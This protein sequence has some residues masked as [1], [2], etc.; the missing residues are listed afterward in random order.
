MRRKTARRINFKITYDD[1]TIPELKELLN[2]RNIDW[3]KL[4][5]SGKSSH[6][7][8][9]FITALESS[10]PPKPRYT[11]VVKICP[12]E[13]KNEMENMIT[14]H[15]V[16]EYTKGVPPIVF[17]STI[18]QNNF[19]LFYLTVAGFFYEPIID[20]SILERIRE[21]YPEYK[22]NVHQ[23]ATL[24]TIFDRDFMVGGVK[25]IDGYDGKFIDHTYRILWGT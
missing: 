6:I 17:K 16:F 23:D 9:D 22:K 1:M 4:P 2:K 13:P 7:K 15:L 21:N 5:K 20:P 3:K 25:A 10:D 18:E 12:D 19:E 8:Q 24:R 11:P 14:I